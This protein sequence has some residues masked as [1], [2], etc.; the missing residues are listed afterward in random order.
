MVVMN[1]RGIVFLYGLMLGIVIIILGIAL[2]PATKE[3]IDLALADLS[4]SAPA[5]DWDDATCIG[6]DLFKPIVVGG[7][8]AIGLTVLWR[9]R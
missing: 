5:S 6:L 1:K 8:L 3:I 7:I 9:M 2:A 4:C